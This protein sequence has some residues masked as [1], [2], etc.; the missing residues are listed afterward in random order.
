M[1]GRR[2]FHHRSE[3]HPRW[4]QLS[5]P[6]LHIREPVQRICVRRF[7]T[8][9]GCQEVFGYI[10]PFCLDF[11]FR[12]VQQLFSRRDLRVEQEDP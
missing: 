6:V 5:P 2:Q 9:S 12:F 3:V 10:Q 7:L 4:R 11:L 8:Y 1:C